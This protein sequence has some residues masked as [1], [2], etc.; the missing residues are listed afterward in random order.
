MTSKK[1]ACGCLLLLWIMLGHPR[2]AEAAR[3]AGDIWGG[4]ASSIQGLPNYI[5]RIGSQTTINH[6]TDH[7]GCSGTFFARASLQAADVPRL[8]V[9]PN[10]MERPNR[11]RPI[12]FRKTAQWRLVSPTRLW[13]RMAALAK[14]SVVRSQT[15]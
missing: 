3:C 12:Q 10:R 9:P 15:P 4:R 2:V 7:A 5:A 11:R 13:V 1:T 14:S 6:V 8:P